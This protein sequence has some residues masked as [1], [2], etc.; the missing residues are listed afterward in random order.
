MSTPALTITYHEAVKAGACYESLNRMRDSDYIGGDWGRFGRGTPIP[1]TA[2]WDVLGE[3]DMWWALWAVDKTTSR[4]LASDF[5]ARV[6]RF[7][8][9]VRPDDTRPR[10]A[11]SVARAGEAAEAAA[12]AAAWD[13]AGAA[14][15]AAAVA[16]AGSAAWS[17]AVAASWAASWD[18]VRAAAG[19]AARAASW[20]AASAAAWAAAGAAAGDIERR[21]QTA[22]VRAVLSGEREP[23]HVPVTR[24]LQH[25]I[26]DR[27]CE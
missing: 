5:A 15:G 26:N 11:I 14:A 2:V 12:G 18:V 22:H 20:A 4:L 19:S 21:W 8:D 7:F 1:L 24:C 25:Q 10:D 23:G 16:A 13:A 9:A 3:D 6:H 27:T 17:A